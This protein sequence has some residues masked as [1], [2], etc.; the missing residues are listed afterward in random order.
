[1]DGPRRGPVHTRLLPQAGDGASHDDPIPEAHDEPSKRIRQHAPDD[2]ARDLGTIAG[3]QVAEHDW[4]AA[5]GTVARDAEQLGTEEVA[6]DMAH[7]AEDA[8]ADEAHTGF[9]EQIL[10]RV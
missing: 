8:T 9:A 4:V 6:R 3:E 1:M 5:F 10:R 2:D 7:S